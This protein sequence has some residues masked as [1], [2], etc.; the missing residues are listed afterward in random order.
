M[1]GKNR[2]KKL[3]DYV[4]SYVVF[5][6]ETTGTSPK[7]EA[8]IEISALKVVDG[9][10]VDTF[11]TLVNPEKP[12]SPG[13]TAVN[14]ITDDM[15]KNEPTLDIVLPQFNEFIEEYILVGHNIHCFDMKFIWKAAEAL[16]GQTISN[17]YID[18]LPM[19]RKCLPQLAHH[20][21]VDLATYYDIDTAGAHRA[22]Q[23]CIMNQLCFEYMQDEPELTPTKKCPNCNS[24]LLLRNGRY[25]QF[26][27]CTNFP[28]CRYTEN[29]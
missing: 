2:G 1:F 16:F 27:G 12:I 24:E 7:T 19:S 6:L 29:T 25:G 15:V 11:S 13:A 3:S 23:D 28:V 20:R 22:L 9:K 10:V 26:W 17:D 4:S 8:I 14:G 21:L 5:D 18:T